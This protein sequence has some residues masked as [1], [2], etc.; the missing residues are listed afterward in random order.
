MSLFCSE[1]VLFLNTKMTSS[2]ISLC[3]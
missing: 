3:I 1:T 2:L